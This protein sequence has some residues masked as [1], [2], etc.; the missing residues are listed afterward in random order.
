M[1]EYINDHGRGIFKVKINKVSCGTLEPKEDG[2]WDWYP[3]L[4]TGYIPA[5]V[6]RA[7][8]DKLDEINKLWD[9]QV[10]QDVG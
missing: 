7:I 2:Y 6:L 8:A 1:I 10:K 3:V 9:E 5:W 4:R